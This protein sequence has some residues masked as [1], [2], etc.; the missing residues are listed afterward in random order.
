MACRGHGARHA[1]REPRRRVSRS[2]IASF[3]RCFTNQQQP[4]VV[5]LHA[6][7]QALCPCIPKAQ[8]S[9]STRMSACPDVSPAGPLA[10]GNG[11]WHGCAAGGPGSADGPEE[12]GGGGGEGIRGRLDVR[13]MHRRLP[14]RASARASSLNS[15]LHLAPPSKQGN[16]RRTQPHSA[17]QRKGTSGVAHPLPS[18]AARFDTHLDEHDD[19]PRL[20]L[21][22]HHVKQ[23][24]QRADHR[25]L[26]V[27]H[28]LITREKGWGQEIQ[29]TREGGRGAGR[30][31]TNGGCLPAQHKLQLPS[32]LHR[33]S[34]SPSA[35]R[36]YRLEKGK[37]G[38]AARTCSSSGAHVKP[39][40]SCCPAR[41]AL[42]QRA[43][44]TAPGPAVDW[45]QAGR[46]SGW[47]TGRSE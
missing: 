4:C 16:P 20:R 40:F 27:L 44:Q 39:H 24:L 34:S 28:H 32:S 9:T 26:L 13:S 8:H 10:C 15:L 11:R 19:G 23:G 21:L 7:H 6:R 42:R 31:G 30:Q 18:K 5:Q 35:G 43:R 2:A 3:S 36:P 45:R 33:R 22:H 17:R 46:S 38:H 47:L 29:E 1:L 41:L 37:C 14:R 12:G 25:V